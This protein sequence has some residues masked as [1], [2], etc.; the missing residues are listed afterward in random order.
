MKK[1]YLLSGVFVLST[2]FSPALS[3]SMHSTLYSPTWSC[4]N[5]HPNG[6][7]TRP[8][9]PCQDCHANATGKNYSDLSAPRVEYHSSAV[10]GSTT[11]G[12]WER[13]C[14][15]CHNPHKVN[16]FD[17]DAGVADSSYVL[18]DLD[19]QNAT[20]EGIEFTFEITNKTVNNP[21]WSDPQTW[22]SKTGQE[23]GLLFV[24]LNH[25][26]YYFNKVVRATDDTI[27]IRNGSKYNNFPTVPWTNPFHAQLIY[28]QFIRDE[29]NGRP[30]H[31]SSPNAM[32]NDESGTGDDPTPDGICQVCHTQTT[33]WRNDGSLANHFNGWDCITCHPHTQGF[34]PVP[35]PVQPQPCND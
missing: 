10:I 23:R 13:Q 11:Y 22:N 2:L 25:G 9:T 1:L 30:V 31:F 27:T 19:V 16:G 15:D 21:N 12:D 4:T 20:R 33:H 32:A 24:Y 7:G 35:P 14:L 5:C 3:F 26:K 28:G 8:R 29:V 17:G 6:P 18:V 34:K